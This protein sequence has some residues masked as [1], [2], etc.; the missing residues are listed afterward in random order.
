MPTPEK[1]P[2]KVFL[3][4][5]HEDRE[6]VRS[7]YTRLKRGGVDVWLDK[8]KLLPGADW[9]YEICKAVRS[10]DVVIVCL[11]KQF[12]QEGFRQKEVRLAL[13]TAMEKPDGEIFIIPARLE[14]CETL[15]SLS[16]WHWVD[17]FED[18]GYDKLVLALRQRANSIG[19]TLRTHRQSPNTVGKKP[20]LTE[21]DA[22]QEKELEFTD[23]I[24]LKGRPIFKFLVSPR[25]ILIAAVLIACIG[26][27]LA[28]YVRSPLLV[29]WFNKQGV[30]PVQTPNSLPPPG[31]SETKKPLATATPLAISQRLIF[32]DTFEDNSRDWTLDE[33]MPDF[34]KY[35]YKT[36]V[37]IENGKYYQVVETS[38]SYTRNYTSYSIPDVSE[39]NFC[40]IFDSR[41]AETSEGTSVIINARDNSSSSGIGNYYTFHLFA[42]GD[43]LIESFKNDHDKK[44]IS[45]FEDGIVWNDGQ[46][47]TVKI[48]LQGKDLELFDKQTGRLVY[49]TILPD[50]G[51]ILE[52]GKIM[53]GLETLNPNQK[54]TLELDNVFVYDK[55]P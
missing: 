55:C 26:T 14:E 36:F 27:V 49:K 33:K 24:I 46:V 54:T 44:Q 20:L 5:A 13:D 9:E 18:N 31:P 42:N 4:H 40:L 41:I 22:A 43:G 21:S 23:P 37:H 7:L 12:N 11:S 17:L 39:P 53:F 6:A 32:K 47:H 51:L 1:R 38:E 48:S 19:A 16:K 52:E 28:A 10:V 3:C 35:G 34:N 8:E 29:S 2:L 15:R 30:S 45:V 25:N 50:D